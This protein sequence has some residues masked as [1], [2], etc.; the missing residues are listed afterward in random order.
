MATED[1]SSRIVEGLIGG[2]TR[3]ALEQLMKIFGKKVG[4]KKPKKSKAKK[5]GNKKPKARKRKGIKIKTTK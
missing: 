1:L 2:M 5:V 3:Y 4:N